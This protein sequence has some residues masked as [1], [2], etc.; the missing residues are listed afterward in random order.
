ET[1]C[2]LFVGAQHSAANKPP[3]HYA[4]PRLRKEGGSVTNDLA[5]QFLQVI[6]QLIDSR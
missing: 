2:Y 6:K 4:S 1:S 5:T 3:I